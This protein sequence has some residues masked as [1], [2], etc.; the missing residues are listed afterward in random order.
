MRGRHG[1][2]R[3]RKMLRLKEIPVEPRCGRHHL[4]DTEERRN[5]QQR[6]GHASENG[7]HA[8]NRD[9]SV[10]RHP[11]PGIDDRGLVIHGWVR[12]VELEE[13]EQAKEPSEKSH[14]ANAPGLCESSLHGARLDV[15]ETLVHDWKTPLVV[16]LE[17]LARF[18]GPVVRA[19]MAKQL[20]FSREHFR[21]TSGIPQ[22]FLGGTSRFGKAIQ[23]SGDFLA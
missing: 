10:K 13:R 16:P 15:T 22:S 1:R 14:A 9:Q 12:V 6:F 17:F 11:R 21:K 23:V 8:Q 2:A 20:Q 4:I 19:I 5:H 3:H 18:H 7:N